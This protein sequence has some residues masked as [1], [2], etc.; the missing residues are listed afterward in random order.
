M[1]FFRS[2]GKLEAHKVATPDHGRF[3]LF[4]A[5]ARLAD[6]LP[7]LAL[8]T[9]DAPARA[10]FRA[11]VDYEK[12]ASNGVMRHCLGLAEARGFAAHPS[13]WIPFF[14]TQTAGGHPPLYQPW[15]DW[16]SDQGLTPYHQGNSLTEAN[17]SRWKPKPREAVWR[18]M[19]IDDPHRA[20]DL[21]KRVA[22]KQST[23]IRQGLLRQID[24]AGSFHGNFPRQIPLL[25]FFLE[26]R[27]AAIRDLAREKLD[28][29]AG[30]ES[31][32]AH[33]AALARFF[34]IEGTSVT[35]NADAP[36]PSR[37]HQH[38]LCATVDELATELGL[39]P[40]AFVQMADLD[41]L[42]PLFVLMVSMTGDVATRST[43]ANRLLDGPSDNLPLGL[44]QGADRSLWQCGLK[45][46]FQS[47]YWN[48]VQ[49]FLGSEMGTLSAAQMKE[50]RCFQAL[51]S[52]VAGPN[53]SYDPIRAI[54]FCVSREAAD[55]A[56]RTALEQGV[57]ADSPRLTMLRF[58]LAL[59][60]A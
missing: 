11:V 33:S 42:G 31:S 23:A 37:L 20:L 1:I 3:A 39:A 8:P 19:T 27:N 58:N 46:L 44:F 29:M 4:R 10:A 2:I 56:L 17:W 45:A 14:D 40:P 57:V 9:M 30:F 49:E 34:K 51:Q 48:S 5:D 7:K 54:A 12:P 41:A 35:V 43:L 53:L 32:V 25:E 15:V 55:V 18:R 59:Q 21:L 47:N 38:W 52:G 60:K 36:V 16:L 22:P 50:M 13:D 6:A 26:D 28:A 24:A